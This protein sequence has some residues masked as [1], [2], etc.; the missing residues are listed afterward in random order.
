MQGDAAMGTG[1]GKVC[2]ATGTVLMKHIGHTYVVQYVHVGN[3][4]RLE[5]F[6]HVQGYMYHTC[7]RYSWLPA[8]FS[9]TSALA[10]AL[11]LSSFLLRAHGTNTG[12]RWL[13]FGRRNSFLYQ[14]KL[15][16]FNFNKEAATCVFSLP[17]TE[18]KP[19]PEPGP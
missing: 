18:T 15:P 14:T 9:K 12:C 3:E 17:M 6:I 8:P 1:V 4:P 16:N 5:Q 2:K 7:T 11:A 13:R 10:Q 19:G